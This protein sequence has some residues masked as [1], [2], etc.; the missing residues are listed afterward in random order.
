[1]HP[2]LTVA[3]F[4]LAAAAAAAAWLG[5]VRWVGP[6]PPDPWAILDALHALA[7]RVDALEDALH[8]LADRVDALETAGALRAGA[9]EALNARVD[10]LSDA[11]RD[12][13]ERWKVL[14]AALDAEAAGRTAAVESLRD[15]L[16]TA[17]SSHARRLDKLEQQ[18]QAVPEVNRRRAAALRQLADLFFPLSDK[19]VRS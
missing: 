1:M 11:L 9:G 7:D 18:Q 3:L 6:R 2:L 19:E 13:G 8:A 12:A 4:A 17:T 14:T 16:R 10:T 15:E 5:L